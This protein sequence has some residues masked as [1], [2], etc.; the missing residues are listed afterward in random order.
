MDSAKYA[1]LCCPLPY[2]LS[3]SQRQK[4]ASANRIGV[5]VFFNWVMHMHTQPHTHTHPHSK[6]QFSFSWDQ[7]GLFSIIRKKSLLGY[8]VYLT[9]RTGYYVTEVERRTTEFY[10]EEIL[11]MMLLMLRYIWSNW[12]V[13]HKLIAPYGIT[14]IMITGFHKSSLHRWNLN[15]G[16][17][18]PFQCFNLTY[19]VPADRE[20]WRKRSGMRYIR[21][22]E[23]R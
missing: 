5:V 6:K 21:S 14:D 11:I 23:L 7:V 2:Q 19:T 20:N 16:A 13:L 4:S 15:L 3:P 1:T 22:C 17:S 18:V 8:S 10:S 9:V 12:N